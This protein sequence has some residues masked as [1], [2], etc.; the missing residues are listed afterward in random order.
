MP[1]TRHRSLHSG[2][3]TTQSR[4]LIFILT[5]LSLIVSWRLLSLT[6][7]IAGLFL[8]LLGVFSPGI[9]DP[10]TRTWLRLGSVLAKV[11]NPLVLGFIYMSV[12]APVSWVRKLMRIDPLDR[13]MAPEQSSYWKPVGKKSWRLDA[14][15]RQY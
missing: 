2:K 8:F 5:F 4:Q 13:S 12:F 14:F 6:W 9:F 10:I 15:R 3:L 1:I 7:C 11:V